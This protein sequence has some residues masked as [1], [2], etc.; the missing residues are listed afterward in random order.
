MVSASA[1]A[2]RVL[3]WVLVMTSLNGGL[4]TRCLSQVDLLLSKLFLVMVF[5]TAT[6]SK[7]IQGVEEC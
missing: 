5:I 2:S 3:P 1:S 4:V 7:Q 6:E